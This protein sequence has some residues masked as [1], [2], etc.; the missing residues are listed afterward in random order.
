MFFSLLAT[1]ACGPDPILVESGKTHSCNQMKASKALAAKPGD[2]DLAKQVK[3]H[4]DRLRLV[5]ETADEGKR[6][7]LQAA[8][9]KA[10]AEGC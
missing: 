4:A 3:E 6:A 1:A 8:I 10:V 2:A 7:A 5:I 9:A